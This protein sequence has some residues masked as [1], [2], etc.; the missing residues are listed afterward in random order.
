[1]T[2]AYAVIEESLERLAERAGDPTTAVYARL[3]ALYPETEALFV[4]DVDGAV[5]GEMLAKVF[6]IALDLA[7]PNAYAANF[8]ACEIVNHDGVGVP[9]ETF[10]RFFDVAVDTFAELLGPD[11]TPAYD[12]AWRGLI[13]RIGVIA[14]AA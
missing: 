14:A 10:P 4:R 2:T 6:E 1:M 3:F 8:I 11:W 13:A 12:A 7:G 5:K 9:R